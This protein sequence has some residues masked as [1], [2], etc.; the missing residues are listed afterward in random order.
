[1]GQTILG[2]GNAAA[3]S[4]GGGSTSRL[5]TSIVKQNP[6]VESCAA[7]NTSYS[8]SGLFGIYGV[9]HPDKAGEMAT[10]MCSALK[11]LTTISAD[12]LAKAKVQLKGNIFR[13]ADDASVTMQ[14]LGHQLLMG[15]SFGSSADFAKIIDGI[16]ADQVVAAA[17][18]VLSSRPTVA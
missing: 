9:S 14:D 18:K 7:F 3:S 12:E 6:H 13:Q 2:G 10:A 11:G 17:K 4:F 16:S 8:D 1:M 15:G 5:A